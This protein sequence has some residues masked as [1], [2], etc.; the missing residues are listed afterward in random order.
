MFVIMLIFCE[1]TYPKKLWEKNWSS[2]AE[3][4][5]H[6]ERKRMSNLH[7]E[8]TETQIKNLTLV[9]I[10][11][12]MK[13]N[14]RTLAEFPS[15][16]I[17]EKEK[18]YAYKNK[19]I[20]EELDYDKE[21]LRTQH[22]S[23]KKGLNSVQREIF[24]AVSKSIEEGNGGLFFVYGSGGTGKT[25]LWNTIITGL[26]AK[27]KIVLAVA[28]SGIASLLLPG[29]RT[30]HSR[31]K[32]PITLEDNSTCD[33]SHGTQLAG[34]ICK[35]E[36]IIWD[37]APMIHRHAFEALERTVRDLMN[38]SKDKTKEK[39]FGGKTL[40]LGGDFRQI[41]P[42]IRGGSRE[43]IVDSSI[44]RSKLWKHF[45]VFQLSENM[46]LLKGN[47][48]S[49]EKQTISK[50]GKWILDLGDG[51]LPEKAVEGEDEDPTW[52]N[53]PDDLLIKADENPIETIVD[54]VYSEL[55]VRF[56][57]KNYLR[58]RCILAPKNETVDH[59]NDYVVFMLPGEE[60]IFL[61]SDSIS[62]QSYN[63]EN[64][65]LL[66][67]QEYL[68]S[69]KLSGVPNH[70]IRLKLHVPIMLT[71][72]INPS[73]GLCNGIRLI[74]TKICARTIQTLI[75]TGSGAGRSACIPRIVIQPTETH[76]PFILRRV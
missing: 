17:P 28:S 64:A 32:I 53:I 60:H 14:G 50:F 65:E 10:E 75:I 49:A 21:K 4:I 24:D 15:M 59:I 9:D 41:L 44:S 29:G 56:K 25:Y 27:S 30:A 2:L 62:P 48:T 16:P 42:V 38:P 69:Q 6:R 66:Y 67:N 18:E 54:V 76:L 61:S 70:V 58:E 57:D 33:V 68:N 72:N 46:R 36:I 20:D 74:V 13:R 12:L 26:R 51:K 73:A 3:G 1:V 22:I 11:E 7:L 55:I 5:Q 19:L 23:L 43:N 47:C 52:I 71:R 37:E 34:L 39:L 35:A 63:F 45:H 40:L 8:L 31:F